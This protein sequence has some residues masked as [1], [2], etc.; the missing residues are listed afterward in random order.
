MAFPPAAP[1]PAGR[2]EWPIRIYRLGEEPGDDLSASTSP[3]ERLEMVWELS[4]RM[5]ALTG[6]DRP[7]Q[8]RNE[9]PVRVIRRA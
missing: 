3:Q 6:R 5:W 2:Y 1:E 4:R 8:A 7:A 9:L